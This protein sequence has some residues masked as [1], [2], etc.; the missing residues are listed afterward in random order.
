MA[1]LPNPI[2][3]DLS[4]PSGD[5]TSRSLSNERSHPHEISIH[6]TK[7]ARPSSLNGETARIMFRVNDSAFPMFVPTGS[8][9]LSVAGIR[10]SSRQV[11]P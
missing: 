7:H 10:S 8:R 11:D 4:G 1:I 2:R 5:A 3:I 6:G 9:L